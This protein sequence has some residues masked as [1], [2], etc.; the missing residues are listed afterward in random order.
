MI[1][2]SGDKKKVHKDDD[3]DDDDWYDNKA[4]KNDDHPVGW[5]CGCRI[6]RGVTSPTTSVLDMTLNNL[7]VKFQ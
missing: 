3:N 4:H 7:M 6:H 2:I 1:M 5:M